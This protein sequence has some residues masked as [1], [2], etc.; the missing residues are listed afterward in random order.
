MKERTRRRKEINK[1]MEDLEETKG[2]E[3]GER[4]R[5]MGD[6]ERKS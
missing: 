2:R 5:E 3:L 1:E 6:E 4:K